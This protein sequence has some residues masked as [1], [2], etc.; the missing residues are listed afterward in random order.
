MKR[1]I[2]LLTAAPL[3]VV[4]P[5]ATLAALISGAIFTCGRQPRPPDP[6]GPA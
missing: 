3:T 2:A 6:S 1:L 5:G 4:I